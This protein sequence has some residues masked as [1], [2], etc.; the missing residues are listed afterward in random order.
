MNDLYKKTIYYDLYDDKNNVVQYHNENNISTAVIWGYNKSYI[1]AKIENIQ[2]T[3]I[4]ASTITNLQNL[5]N[6][7]I[8]FF[9]SEVSIVL[10][11]LQ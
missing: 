9:H 4:P 2:Y 8:C 3:S 11:I 6:S 7:G 10:Y 5:S 1:I